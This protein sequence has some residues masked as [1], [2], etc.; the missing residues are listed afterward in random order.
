MQ[1]PQP[2]HMLSSLVYRVERT[3]QEITQLKNQLNSYVPARENELRLQSINEA[4]GRIEQDI[5][6]VKEEV[7]EFGTQLTTQREGID[8]LLIRVLWGGISLLL[9]VGIAVLIGYITNLFR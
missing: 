1:H 2:E 5:K 4:V 8:K 7:K 6:E 3:E 9:G